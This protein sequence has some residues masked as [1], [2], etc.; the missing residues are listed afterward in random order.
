MA[1]LTQP[2]QLHGGVEGMIRPARLSWLQFRV[3]KLS[4]KPMTGLSAK[5]TRDILKPLAAVMPPVFKYSPATESCFERLFDEH[6]HRRPDSIV[7]ARCVLHELILWLGRDYQAARVV[8]DLQEEGLSLPIRNAIRWL[9]LHLGEEA[10]VAQMAH[11]AAMSERHFR[12]RFLSEVGFTPADYVTRRRVE[13][14]RDLLP[15]ADRSITDIALELGFS[16]PAYF[17]AVFRKYTGQTPTEFRRT[18]R[19]VL[20]MSEP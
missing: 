12:C 16:T 4:S 8:S 20:S 1:I 13:R 11:A 3:P 15:Q 18:R 9:N 2:G 7:M 19:G 10:S 17:A 6:R 5:H 14:A